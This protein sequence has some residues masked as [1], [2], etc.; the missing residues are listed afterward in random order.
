MI[1]KP[2]SDAT[3]TI[4]VIKSFPYRASKNLV[5]HNLDLT[6]LTVGELMERVK[7]EIV[8]KPGWKPYK[9]FA[10]ELDAMKLYTK[11]HGTKTT[12]LIINME[13]KDERFMFTDEGKTLSDYGCEHETEVSIFKLADYEAFKANPEEKW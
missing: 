7:H 13:D 1:D 5:L 2:L 12:N 3:L 10:L 11:A 4:R 9:A 8:D 6:T